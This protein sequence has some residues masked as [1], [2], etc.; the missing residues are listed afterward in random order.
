MARSERGAS[1]QGAVTSERRRQTPLPHRAQRVASLFALAGVARL[2]EIARISMLHSRLGHRENRQQRGPLQ[3][4]DRLLDGE[5]RYAVIGTI[6][7]RPHT[8][9]I[10][11]RGA[12]TRIISAR[13]ASK[14]ENQIYA[15]H[16]KK[17]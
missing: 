4:F 6:K 8:A 7:G 16:I 12:N 15:K 5:A 17:P 11:Y 2:I 14:E 13:P 1:P 10:T 3:Y 9:I